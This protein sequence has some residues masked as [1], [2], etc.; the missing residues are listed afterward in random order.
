MS[1]VTHIMRSVA[2]E[3]QAGRRAALCAIV[4]TQGSTPQP[5]GALLAILASGES[6]GT[7]GGGC[8]EGDVIRRAYALIPDGGSKVLTFHL[9]HTTGDYSGLICG[10]TMDVAISVLSD[11]AQTKPLADALE[12]IASGKAAVLPIYVQTEDGKLEYRVRIAAPPKL[13][14]AGAGHISRILAPLAASVGFRVSVIDD[15]AQY[16]NEERFPKPLSA[17]VG[18]IEQA[19]A[20]WPIDGGTYVV[21]VTRGHL[22]DQRALRAILGSPAR[23]IGMIGSWQKI[24]TIFAD[25]RRDGASEEQLSRVHAPIG[26]DIGAVTTEEI[27]V[28]IAAELI[29][30]HR[31]DFRSTVEGPFKSDSTG[32]V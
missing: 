10:G 15:R 21:I 3:V 24:E 26:I 20:T 23:Y 11:V 7:L 5:V 2:E 4:A 16:A 25:L 6:V 1:D 31:R 27:A 29:A 19:L 8:V 13:V 28:S 17:H 18:N 9:D 30:E 14:I 32:H 22:Y 12:S